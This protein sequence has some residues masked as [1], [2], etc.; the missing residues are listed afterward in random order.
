MAKWAGVFVLLAL[1]AAVPANA[2]EM[3]R[4]EPEETPPV[5]LEPHRNC[6]NFYEDLSRFA[7]PAPSR[8]MQSP[9]LRGILRGEREG[10]GRI[11]NW[12]ICDE[13][14]VYGERVG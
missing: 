12:R 9:S 8:A 14:H 7:V 2:Q 6:D 11:C 3:P 1:G 4:T 10:V 13:Q 5:A